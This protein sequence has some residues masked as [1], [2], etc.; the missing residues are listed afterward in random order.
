MKKQ[1]ETTDQT[2]ANL[3]E[4]FWSLY[5]EKRIDE[6]T[7]KEISARAGYNRGTFYEY[8]SDVRQCLRE[9]EALSLPRFEELP[10]LPGSSPQ[11]PEVFEAF[12]TLYEEKFRYFDVL[13]GDRGDPSFQRRLIEGLKAAILASGKLPQPADPVEQDFML[14][15]ILSGLI[16][17]MRHFF[18]SYPEGS[19]A[20]AMAMVYRA[21]GKDVFRQLTEDAGQEG[22]GRAG[23]PGLS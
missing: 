1:P 22:Q 16:G 14:E 2:R 6:I 21:M 7:V 23:H 18:H 15:Y 20:E 17:V 10:P 13:L 5:A 3:L 19:R 9:I 12:A 4:A 8:F 11:G